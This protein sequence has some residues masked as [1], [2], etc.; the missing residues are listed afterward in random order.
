M[1]LVTS[2]VNSQGNEIIQRLESQLQE[3]KSKLKVKNA[4]TL[5]QEKLLQDKEKACA[6]LS[7]DM[8]SP[9]CRKEEAEKE[10]ARARGGGGGAIT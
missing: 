1:T 4:V 9:Y 6:L 7:P 5:H 2:W 3:A 8:T 10:K